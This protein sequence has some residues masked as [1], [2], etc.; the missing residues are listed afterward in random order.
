MTNSEK[1]TRKEIIN[2]RLKL[3]GWDVTDRTS[4]I[5]EFE[6]VFKKNSQR[7]HQHAIQVTN[8]VIIFFQ[9]R[10]QCKIYSHT[11]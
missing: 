9:G 11:N 1:L 8:S 5:E 4:V 3:A 10:F 6:T 7:M 2:L